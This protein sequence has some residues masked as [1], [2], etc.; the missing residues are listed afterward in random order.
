MDFH[1]FRGRVAR[2]SVVFACP[3]V[4]PAL[5]VFAFLMWLGVFTFCVI[6]VVA[7]ALA[8]LRVALALVV[9]ACP[10]VAPALVGLASR[11]ARALVLFAFS[12]EAR[13]FALSVRLR[14]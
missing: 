10:R 9:F 14:F 6:S 13:A 4:A 12:S 11:V 3:R 8:A 7:R 5:V 1:G 2:P